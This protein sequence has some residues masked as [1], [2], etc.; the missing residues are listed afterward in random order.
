MHVQG[1]YAC[2]DIMSNVRN[3]CNHKHGG[4]MIPCCLAVILSGS[5]PKTCDFMEGACVHSM[6]QNEWSSG[7]GL[8]TSTHFLETHI[9]GLKLKFVK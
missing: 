8:L 1:L 2:V 7:F 9:L 6:V 5:I 4:K 3:T